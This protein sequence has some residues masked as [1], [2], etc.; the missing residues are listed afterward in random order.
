MAFSKSLWHSPF[1]TTGYIALFNL[2][3][4]FIAIGL[5]ATGMQCCWKRISALQFTLYMA[6]YNL[7]QTAG[8]ALM[9][10]LRNRLNWEYTI[11]SFSA[12]AGIALI[13]IQFVRIKKHLQQLERLDNHISNKPL[14]AKYD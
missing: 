1:F 2:L 11:L 5:F 8:S 12:M 3:F 4:V 13:L 10:P 6:I 9:G 14:K 7:G